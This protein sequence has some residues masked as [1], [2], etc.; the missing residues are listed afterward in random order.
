MKNNH[1]TFRISFKC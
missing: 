1:R